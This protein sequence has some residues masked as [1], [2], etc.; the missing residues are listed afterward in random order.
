M[1]KLKQCGKVKMILK[2]SKVGMSTLPDLK[3]SYKAALMQQ[4]VMG[5]GPGGWDPMPHME[6]P[7]FTSGSGCHAQL[8]PGSHSSR[9]GAP[10]TTWETLT[11]T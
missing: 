9:G 5:A 11:E 1:C 3:T 6:V 7:E 2:V 10:A 4:G 8:P